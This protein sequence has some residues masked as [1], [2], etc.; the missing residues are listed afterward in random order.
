MDIWLTPLLTNSTDPI[1][2]FDSLRY[3]ANSIGFSNLEGHGSFYTELELRT[4][5]QGNRYHS[6][7]VRLAREYLKA[8]PISTIKIDMPY[9]LL[10]NHFGGWEN[11]KRISFVELLKKWQDNPNSV[12]LTIKLVLV[13]VV[14]P[15]VSNTVSTT[16]ADDLPAGFIHLTVAENLIDSTYV[17]NASWYWRLLAAG[18]IVL[19]IYIFS[20]PWRLPYKVSAGIVILIVYSMFSIWLFKTT[21]MLLPLISPFAIFVIITG[22]LVYKVYTSSHIETKHQAQI[23]SLLNEK[24]VELEAAEIRISNLRSEIQDTTSVSEERMA[25]VV[26]GRQ[27]IIQL[28]KEIRDLKATHIITSPQ[29][30]A[31]KGNQ[32]IIHSPNGQMSQ[33][34]NTV[35]TF[36]KSDMPILIIGETGTGKELIAREL[37]NNSERKNYP[38]VA[39]NCGALSS[40]LLLSELFGHTK[41]SFTGASS[42]RKGRFE[43]ADKGTLFLDEITET[44]RS[45][46]AS[47]LRV[48]QEG[49]FERIGD[50]VTRQVD[51]RI[52]AATNRDIEVEISEQR[53]RTDLYYR[54]NGMTIELPALEQR[55]EDIPLLA[56]HFIAKHFRDIHQTKTVDMALSE[57]TLNKLSDYHW[58]G[59]VR[60]LENIIQRAVLLAQA[61]GRSLVRLE[62]L[63]EEIRYTDSRSKSSTE[64]QSIEEQILI[65]L[66]ELKFS[67]S[68]I[69]QTA[70]KLGNRDRGTITEYLRGIVFRSL[71]DNN[72]D[73]KEAMIALAGSEENEVCANA[74]RK[75]NDYLSNLESLI[76]NPAKDA[77]SAFRGLPKTYHPYLRQLIDHLKKQ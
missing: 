52:V 15:G 11:V 69:T 44:D 67:R 30:K 6:F 33:V 47:L 32:S 59:N 8:S 18:F 56:E 9:Q 35:Q 34:L 22:M 65:S 64:F 57:E 16:L 25:K 37:H 75:I 28:E 5:H 14:Y 74:A 13:C 39:V 27:N 7:G 43:L 19:L 29:T 2:P 46:Q 58:P 73:K 71:A 63:P 3:S 17:Q 68:A 48:L 70:R 36:G 10:P 76:S 41:G 26:A 20:V 24:S 21:N 54:L 60:E 40:E 38:F 1:F 77:N 66:R 51:V 72:F 62:D 12:D 31:T 49:T 50:E 4:K 55:S 45:F 53:F 23:K 61:A 42:D